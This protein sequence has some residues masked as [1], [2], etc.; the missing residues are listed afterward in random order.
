MKHFKRTLTWILLVFIAAATLTTLRPRETVFI[1]NG[2]CVLFWHA[3]KRCATCLKMEKSLRK[4]LKNH[5]DFRLVVLEYD[6]FS[7]QSLAKQFDVG[8]TTIILLERKDQQ[9]VRIRDLTTEVWINIRNN[10]AYFENMLQKEL[11]QFVRV[12][13]REPV[14]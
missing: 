2:L 12:T 7:N 11:E 3:E 5:K 8:T 9:N 13:E 14:N 1:P 4:T 10:E 6:V